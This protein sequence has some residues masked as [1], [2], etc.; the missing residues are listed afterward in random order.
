V[1]KPTLGKTRQEQKRERRAA[2]VCQVLVG[3]RQ[4]AAIAG[5]RSGATATTCGESGS[6]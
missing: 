1:V 4:H 5:T 3:E 6:A 2:Q